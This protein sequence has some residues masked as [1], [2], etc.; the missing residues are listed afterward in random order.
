MTKMIGINASV[1]APLPNEAY[2]SLGTRL[3]KNGE[4]NISAGQAKSIASA[5]I[6][7][8]FERVLA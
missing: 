3:A 1:C 8:R 4:R 2:S 6:I 5:A 7:S